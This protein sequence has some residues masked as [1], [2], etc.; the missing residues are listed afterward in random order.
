MHTITYS[1]KLGFNDYNYEHQIIESFADEVLRASGNFIKELLEEFQTYQNQ[2]DLK[3][4]TNTNNV[5]EMLLLGTLWRIYYNKTPMINKK[6]TLSWRIFKNINRRGTDSRNEYSNYNL[7]NL[8][9]LFN[10]L[11]SINEFKQ[12]F[13]QLKF[14]KKFFETLTQYKV[15]KFLRDAVIFADWFKTCSK[16]TIGESTA[17]REKF[18]YYIRLMGIEII[19]LGN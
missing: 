18:L 11:E 3:F 4:Q 5:Y 7:E 14:L 16:F 9:K 6:H 10:Y 13:N 8:N 12:E 15:S 1:N 19:K 2:Q 17:N